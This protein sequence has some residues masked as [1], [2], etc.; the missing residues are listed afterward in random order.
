[1]A[2]RTALVLLP[3][4][5]SATGC[6]FSVPEAE[7]VLAEEIQK[8][9]KQSDIRD[10]LTGRPKLIRVRSYR[11]IEGGDIHDDHWIFLQIGRENLSYK[12]LIRTRSPEE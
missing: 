10:V 6:S 4:L 7:N 5:L 2:K 12:D 1:M 8:N 3:I 9:R 11:R